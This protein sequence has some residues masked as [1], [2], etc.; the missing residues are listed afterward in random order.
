MTGLAVHRGQTEGQNKG[1]A[2]IYVDLNFG[3]I[4]NNVTGLVGVMIQLKVIHKLIGTLAKN[5]H[6]HL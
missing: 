5:L 4:N 3:I 6:I 1:N 2:N